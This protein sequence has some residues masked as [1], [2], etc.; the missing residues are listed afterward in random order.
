L[1][2]A[3]AKYFGQSQPG[4]P[5]ARPPAARSCA[6]TTRSCRCGRPPRA[7]VANTP[8]PSAAARPCPAARLSS[9]RARG[10]DLAAR[11]ARA[12]ADSPDT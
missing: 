11:R 5:A 10:A 1:L 6:K 3:G 8:S 7:P 4:A 9:C 12:Y 2:E